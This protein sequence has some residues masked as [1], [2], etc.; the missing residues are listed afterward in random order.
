MF[1][2]G[3]K[4]TTA[5]RRGG[6]ESSGKFSSFCCVCYAYVLHKPLPPRVEPAAH[7]VS[8]VLSLKSRHML[9]L[10]TTFAMRNVQYAW[11][12]F[13]WSLLGG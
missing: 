7:P 4:T 6:G 5:R 2:T 1:S 12:E 10:H 3:G 8:L 13:W 9:G 11:S